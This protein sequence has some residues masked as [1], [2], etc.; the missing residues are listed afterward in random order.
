MTDSID[1]MVTVSVSV[2]SCILKVNS[3][4][5]HQGSK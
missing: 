1:V 5:W 4:Y 2:P 3:F